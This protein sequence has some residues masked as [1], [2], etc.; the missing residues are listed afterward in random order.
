MPKKIFIVLIL[1]FIIGIL[2]SLGVQIYESLQVSG[3]LEQEAEEL[4]NLE[5]KNSELKKK[6]TE[7]QS[8]SFIEQQTRNKLGWSRAGE[9]VV[10]IPQEELDKVLGVK[11]EVQKI[12]EPYWQGWMKLFWK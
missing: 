10:I 6:L 8:L 11:E 9:T 5:K 4:V 2:Y 1:I 3:R 12:I 7:V